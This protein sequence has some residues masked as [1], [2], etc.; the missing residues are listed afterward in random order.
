MKKPTQHQR[1]INQL[2]KYGY[3]SRNYFINLSYDRILR[4][5]AIINVLRN[6][7]WDL[8]TLE[9]NGDTVYKVKNSPYRKVVYKVADGREIITHEK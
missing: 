2:L 3:V 1:V 6:E 7:G 5:G 8:E 4:L 9:E